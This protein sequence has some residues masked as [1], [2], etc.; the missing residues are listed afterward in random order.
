MLRQFLT[1]LAVLVVLD[2]IWLGV[3]MKD[4]YRRSLAP[5]ARMAGDSLDPIWPI[6]VLVYPVMAIGLTVL[7]LS[8]AR[9]AAEALWLGAVFGAVSFA[10]YDL[11]NH[12]TLREWQTTM[13]LVDICWGAFSCG[14]ASWVAVASSRV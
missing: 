11:T 9:T 4:F 5:V 8:R 1:A 3:L 2:G 6:A 12:A 7:V 14:A 13:T 10:V